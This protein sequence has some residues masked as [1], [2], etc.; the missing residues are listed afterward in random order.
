[1]NYQEL[2]DDLRSQKM[3]GKAL[4]QKRLDL[5]QAIEQQTNRPL[6]I[7]AAKVEAPREAPNQIILEDVIGFTDLTSQVGGDSIDV[8]IESP[9]GSVDAAHRVVQI[10]RQKYTSIRFIVPGSAYSAATMIALSG[11]EILMD[12]AASLGPIDPQINGIPARSILNG[13][14]A[15]RDVL[16]S[17][18][19][20]ALPAYLPLLQ[21][22]DLHIFEICK[23][24]EERGKQLVCDWLKTYMF[25]DDADKD[26]KA[27]D[28]VGFFAD[29]D[30]HKSHARPIF[31]TDAQKI[32]VNVTR[33]NETPE[34][35]SNVWDL[36]LC[37]KALFDVSINVK[38]FE[39]RH[40][41]N[42]GKQ[43]IPPGAKVQVQQPLPK[44][45]A[46][47]PQR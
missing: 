33:L 2:L 20:S 13:F 30:T 24:A 36:F 32:G 37:I 17:E 42:W 35:R 11:D 46:P 31:L 23:D 5:M 14:A 7:Y 34:L 44:N 12:D 16:K 28:V 1:M 27:E 10:L 21:K 26:Q 29:Y 45:P 19:P 4:H 47:K 15:V 43:F 25:K 38:I 3:D 22:Y 8:L 6:V 41:V 39:N 40:G 18:G 9:G